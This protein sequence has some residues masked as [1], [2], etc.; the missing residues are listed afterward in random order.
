M[1]APL[2]VFISYSHADEDLFTKLLE[3]LKP[4]ERE[5]LIEGWHDRKIG[6]GSEWAGQ[7]DQNLEAADIVLALVSPSFLASDYISDVEM[8]SALARANTSQ[9]LVIPIILRPGGSWR[10]S[11]LGKLQVLPKNGKPVVDWTTPDHAFEDV[12]E[13]LR[14][15][16]NK[17]ERRQPALPKQQRRVKVR[18]AIALALLLLAGGWWWRQQ[19]RYNAAGN[20]LLDIGRYPQAR[21]HYERALRLNPMSRQARIG[22]RKIELAGVRDEPVDFQ[23]RLR[24]LQREAPRDA[25]VKVLEGDYLYGIGDPRAKS[26][27]EEAIRLNPN[28]A[29]AYF[30]LGVLY[31][32]QKDQRIRRAAFPAYQEAVKLSPASPHYAANLADQHFKRGEYDLA[33]R[34]YD[35][36]ARYPLGALEGAKIRRLQ[37]EL[38]E[39]VQSEMKA[40]EWLQQDAVT[41]LPEN[42]LPWY[43]DVGSVAL[44]S[45]AD[46]E[47]Y[48]HLS[49]SA[50]LYLR[51]DEM[52]AR[53]QE[54][55]AGCPAREAEIKAVLAA[56]LERVAEEQQHL[57]Q[58]ANEYRAKLL[59]SLR[60]QPGGD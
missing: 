28:L 22:L 58:R 1:A 41:G 50:T 35:N 47:C 9:T 23:Q 29:E 49:L 39:A 12:I 32:Q 31:D 54:A 24:Q 42:Q 51:G 30:R 43:F 56:E 55:K 57:A 20:E 38:Q 16:V 46:K 15:A 17:A 7:I 53:E 48:A 3:H 5:G 37:G 34:I 13:G 52:G 36:L 59:A 18:H 8:K 44:N 40:L 26:R 25:H 2:K 27:Y 45:P 6:A 21:P 19:S 60:R 4:L 11:P 10:K 14:R 33:L